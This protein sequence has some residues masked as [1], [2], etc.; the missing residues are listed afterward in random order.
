M[1]EINY[2]KVEEV[3]KYFRD[4][5][6]AQWMEDSFLTWKWWLLLFLTIIPIIIWW[7][8]VD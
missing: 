6:Q 1:N 5:M 3:R 4:L 2:Q 8:I 7:K